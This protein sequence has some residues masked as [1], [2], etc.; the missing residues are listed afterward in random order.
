MKLN[1]RLNTITPAVSSIGL[2]VL[3]AF[4]SF[5]PGLSNRKS[6]NFQYA[7][8]KGPYISIKKYGATPNTGADETVAIQ[9]AID[10]AM[11]GNV[12]TVYFPAGKY[13]TKSINIGPGLSLWGYGV[14][15]QLEPMQGRWARLFDTS[16]KNYT[17]NGNAD[18]APLI[19]R[20]FTFDGNRLNQGPYKHHEL[21]HQGLLFLN[22]DPK[23]HGRL[24]AQVID[25]HFNNAVGDG[26]TTYRNV[27]AVIK[28]ITANNVYRGGVQLDGG[29]NIVNID[30]YKSTGDD[31]VTGL[32]SEPASNTFGPNIITVNNLNLQKNFT[33]QML[34]GSKFTGKSIVAGS[35]WSVMSI[36]GSSVEISDSKLG[37]GNGDV[38]QANNIVRPSHVVF[39]N[40]DFYADD[41]S[42][43]PYQNMQHVIRVLMTDKWT[44]LRNQVLELNNCRIHLPKSG[45]PAW[46][47]NAIYEPGQQRSMNNNIL[48]QNVK[49][50]SGF[51]FSQYPQT[52]FI[53]KK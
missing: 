15:L 26:L 36:E 49:Y 33:I 48:L 38:K 34:A 9:S 14:T 43:P 1:L 44:A 21:E 29:N 8:P 2:I 4:V 10:A 17:Y 32:H 28:N 53:T 46:K 5:K 52:A 31:E 18:S 51:D 39:N 16:N 7:E 25:D 41:M 11:K 3:I 13:M 37:G 6:L 24:T 50:D 42:N 22:A 30:G 12:K 27:N 47:I 20:G 19:V 45:K 35:P 40:V 23:S